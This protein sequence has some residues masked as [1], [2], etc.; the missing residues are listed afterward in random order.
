[1]TQAIGRI[2]LPARIAACAAAGA[3]LLFAAMYKLGVV[4]A[5]V[6]AV[7]LCV[8]PL[9]LLEPA[10]P[11]GLLL[12]AT[13]GF[14][15][16]SGA[17]GALPFLY[18]SLP[19]HT[20]PLELL[21][22][23]SVIA[24][25]V[26][27][28]RGTALRGPWPL[29]WTLVLLAFATLCGAVVG[30]LNDSSHR[31]VL[32]GVRTLLILVLVPFAVVNVVRTREAVH[33][34]LAVLAA[35]TIV[36]SAL[37]IVSVQVGTAFKIGN[38]TFTYYEPV[39]NALCMGYL[40]VVVGCLLRRV[41]LP[42]WVL[43]GSFLVF[44][45]LLLSYRR[46]FWIAA[47]LCL[48]L[49]LAIASGQTSR[50]ILLF[51]AAMFGLALYLTLGQGV[52]SD[53]EVQGPI[54]QRVESLRPSSL[55]TNPEDRY[56]IDE[57]RNVLA[58]IRG[59]PLTGLGIGTPWRTR[60]ALSINRA[61]G[62]DYVHFAALWFWLKLGLVGLAAYLAMML[63]GA[64][65]GLRAWRASRDTLLGVT[66]LGLGITLI[67][68]GVAETTATFTGV[69]PRFNVFLGGL[70]GLLAVIARDLRGHDRVRPL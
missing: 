58:E 30:I 25:L 13:I 66:A 50:P 54:A 37:G 14:E 15:E 10:V 48:L 51:V 62:R 39:V 5:M 28:K 12:L 11:L 49:V 59:S 7:A 53:V 21:V 2:W 61:G 3:L 9:M 52:R 26:S 70:L 22:L 55:T 60:Y 38:T 57:R 31:V 67:G 17:F 24:V 42:L 43:G 35:L 69:S 63:S 6:V 8:A 18:A 33:R 46:S 56:R 23:G 44:A 68:I 4:P 40:V 29:S 47:A 41:R 45:S 34:V 27:Q 16:Q 20:T 1:M 36:K 32:T 19:V 64:L 65:A